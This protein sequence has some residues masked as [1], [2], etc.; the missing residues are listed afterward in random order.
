MGEFSSAG[1]LLEKLLRD[2]PAGVQ[3]GSIEGSLRVLREA[4]KDPNAAAEGGKKIA[5]EFDKMY[6]AMRNLN[7]KKANTDDDK[8]SKKLKSVQSRTPVDI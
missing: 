2:K 3:L 6:S 5:A 4:A 1:Q 7:I 8:S